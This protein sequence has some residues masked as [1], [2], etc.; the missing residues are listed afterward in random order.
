M[1]K[2]FFQKLNILAPTCQAVKILGGW[3]VKFLQKLDRLA[4]RGQNIE[5]W[6]TLFFLSI[7][8]LNF[9]TFNPNLYLCW[10]Y[11]LNHSLEIQTVLLIG[12]QAVTITGHVATLHCG[13]ACVHIRK[14]LFLQMLSLL[15]SFLMQNAM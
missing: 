4:S 7:S 1:L 14:N 5:F 11:P 13:P 10:S 6:E 2:S 12:T 9:V 3:G 15:Y 8:V